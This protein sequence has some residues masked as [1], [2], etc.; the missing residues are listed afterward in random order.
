MCTLRPGSAVDL[1]EIIPLRPGLHM[2][3]FKFG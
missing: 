3:R 2:I 1:M